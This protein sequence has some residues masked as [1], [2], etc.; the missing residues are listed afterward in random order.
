MKLK[1]QILFIALFAFACKKEKGT[2]IPASGVL[3]TGT[4]YVSKM[5]DDGSDETSI[6]YDYT[7]V[8]NTNGEL[9]AACSY[10]TTVGSWYAENDDHGNYEFRIALGN[11]DPLEKLSKRWHV[12]SQTSTKVE[13]YENDQDSEEVTFEKQ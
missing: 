3:T 11:V 9:T 13:L 10:G 6:F 4:W 8:F 12:R 1:V 5:M 7:F 2:G